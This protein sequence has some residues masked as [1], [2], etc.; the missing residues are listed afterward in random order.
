MV[1]TISFCLKTCFP[2]QSRLLIT[3]NSRYEYQCGD[4][5]GGFSGIYTFVTAPETPR[6][7]SIGKLSGF[8]TS[9]RLWGHGN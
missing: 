4:D 2:I 6:P 5:I 8:L 7:F 3:H 9:S 1:I